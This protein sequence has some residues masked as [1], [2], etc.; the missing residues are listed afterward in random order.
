MDFACAETAT[1]PTLAPNAPFVVTWEQ[2]TP[3]YGMMGWDTVQTPYPTLAEACAA[4]SEASTNQTT[5]AFI[6]PPRL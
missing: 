6:E 4:A 1:T 5:R 3:G 2:A